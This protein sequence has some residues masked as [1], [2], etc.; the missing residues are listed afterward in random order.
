MLKNP[1]F[2]WWSKDDEPPEYRPP[3]KAQDMIPNSAE[4]EVLAK[5][6]EPPEIEKIRS[7]IRQLLKEGKKLTLDQVVAAVARDEDLTKRVTKKLIKQ[8]LNEFI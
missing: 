2:G 3:I 8:I 4:D 6:V 5:V 7:I 1:S